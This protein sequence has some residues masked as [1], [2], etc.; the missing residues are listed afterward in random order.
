LVFFEF[1]FPF[2][3]CELAI[4]TAQS[5]HYLCVPTETWYVE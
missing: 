3:V 4:I 2:Y 5:S 1:S